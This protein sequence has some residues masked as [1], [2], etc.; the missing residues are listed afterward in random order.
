MAPDHPAGAATSMD[1]CSPAAG[2]Y[3]DPAAAVEA[4]VDD[5]PD[6]R[7]FATPSHVTQFFTAA[8]AALPAVEEGAQGADGDG[9]ECTASHQRGTIP[10]ANIVTSSLSAVTLTASSTRTRARVAAAAAEPARPLTAAVVAEHDSKMFVV[11]AKAA[12]ASGLGRAASKATYLLVHLVAQHVAGYSKGHVSA[13]SGAFGNFDRV[14]AQGWLVAD[15]LGYDPLLER[16][17]AFILGSAVRHRARKVKSKMERLLRAAQLEAADAAFM[18]A[19]VDPPLPFPDARSATAGSVCSKREREE[20]ESSIAPP[21]SR[22]RQTAQRA[23]AS[24]AAAEAVCES[25]M[26]ARDAADDVAA[27]R[28]AAWEAACDATIAA[29]LVPS[30]TD[31]ARRRVVQAEER[32]AHALALA[33]MAEAELE[34]RHQEWA[35][36]MMRK[37]TAREAAYEAAG[38]LRTAEF[39]AERE[40]REKPTTWW[41]VELAKIEAKHAAEDAEM[42]SPPEAVDW[43]A[44]EQAREQAALVEDAAVAAAISSEAAEQAARHGFDYDPIH[45]PDISDYKTLYLREKTYSQRLR[46]EAD[47]ESQQ[48]LA[49]G[50]EM[51]D[52]MFV[53]DAAVAA[54]AERMGERGERYYEHATDSQ[55]R[56]LWAR[57][58]ALWRVMDE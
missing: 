40:E 21:L 8:D 32:E 44:R 15:A 30:R 1:V 2:R 27:K 4:T 43:V 34:T 18:H 55:K 19:A 29:R 47:D 9:Q 10:T 45:D 16:E 46:R 53:L 22:L 57:V 58:C 23:A 7:G 36:A 11:G 6:A 20:L 5:S 25:A 33:N 35:D 52:R 13:L 17:D 28:H 37:A 39:A 38:A 42:E 24:E 54:A 48:L 14:V 49:W 12:V 56:E 41:Q 26:A 51:R 3:G 50:R 31:A